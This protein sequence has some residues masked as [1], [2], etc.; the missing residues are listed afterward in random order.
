MW[1]F[2]SDAI[3][4]PDFVGLC[5]PHDIEV[6]STTDRVVPD[7]PMFASWIGPEMK[8]FTPFLIVEIVRSFGSLDVSLTDTMK[9]ILVAD[10]FT[11][12]TV[13]PQH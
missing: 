11:V 2:F 8:V 9:L 4:V 6:L 7:F 5:V 12:R 13:D 10:G 1:R 3:D